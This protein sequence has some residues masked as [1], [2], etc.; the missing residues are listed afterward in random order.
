M[1]AATLAPTPTADVL[2]SLEVQPATYDA[3]TRLLDIED[4]ISRLQEEAAALRHELATDLAN[5]ISR[6]VAVRGYHVKYRA[7]YDRVSYDPAMIEAA[8]LA[9][10]EGSPGRYVLDRARKVAISYASDALDTLAQR[11]GDRADGELLYGDLA[12][13]LFEGRRSTPC[14]AT[15]ALVRDRN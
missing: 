10:P 7:A 15:V 2:D 1:T 12:S 5:T 13:V 8:R 9:L 11:I 3:A 4:A 6:S 14:A